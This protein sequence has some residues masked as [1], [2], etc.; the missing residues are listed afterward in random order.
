MESKRLRFILLLIGLVI[1]YF[2]VNNYKTIF[3]DYL[4]PYDQSKFK[5]TRALDYINRYYVDSVA[6][7]T[8]A[9]KAINGAM[10]TLDPHSVY[11]NKIEVKN[12]E[13]S[14]EGRYQGIGIQFDIV[15]NYP[16]V[17]SVI[18]GSPSFKAGLLA[19]DQIIKIDG[20]STYKIS[21]DEVPKKLKGPKGTSVKVTIKRPGLEEPF[22]VTL[23]RAEIPIT[24]INTYFMVDSI[25]G[26][27]WLNRFAHTSS[28]EMEQALDDLEARGMKR[29]VFDL[30]DNGG[31]LLRQ[32]VEIVAKFIKGKKLVVFTR[33]KLKTFNEK[34]YTDFKR[35]TRSYPLI[36][37]INHATASASEI[38]A[39]ALQDYDRAL[40]VG[41]TSFGKGLVQNEFPLPDGSRIRLTVSKYYTP[42]G[43][44]IQRPYKNKSREEYYNELWED[45]LANHSPDT[46]K[47]FYTKNGRKVFGGGGIQPDIFVKLNVP[48]KSAKWV[49][50]LFQKRLFFKTVEKWTPNLKIWSED[51]EKFRRRFKVPASML[52]SLREMAIQEGVRIPKNEFVKDGGYLKNRLKAEIARHFWSMSEFY[53]ILL[54]YDNQFSTALEHF[55]DA[56][57]LLKRDE[58]TGKVKN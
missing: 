34:F 21:R 33:G 1:I 57:G 40:I 8:T 44:L 38:V 10:Q 27:I 19:G 25:T 55:N 11:M 56:E 14:F 46:S 12:A 31:G 42:S 35:K 7:Q 18:P 47:V 2:F 52:R 37:L 41:V 17:I 39:G 54:E 20:K 50:K 3:Y 5:I 29:L 6:W 36:L 4:S 24:T 51:F 43:R 26:Y 58:Y 22:E 48:E 9:D 28:D 32:A 53:R 15:D 45:S 30:R 13:E 16:T 49:V 23:V